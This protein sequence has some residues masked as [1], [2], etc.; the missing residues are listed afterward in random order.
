MEQ[1]KEDLVKQQ[2]Y[3]TTLKADLRKT[4]HRLEVTKDKTFAEDERY[5]RTLRR[6]SSVSPPGRDQLEF[7]SPRGIRC[8]ILLNSVV[9]IIIST[10]N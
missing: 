2:K 10:K 1:L 6:E 5:I 8:K 4:Q 3:I 9:L 7:Q